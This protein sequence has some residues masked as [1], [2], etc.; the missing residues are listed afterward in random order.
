MFDKLKCPPEGSISV[1]SKNSD[2]G[3]IATGR[4]ASFL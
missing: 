4:I 3:F 2:D 1:S